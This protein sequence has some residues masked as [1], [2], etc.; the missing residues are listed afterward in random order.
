M[1]DAL[2]TVTPRVRALRADPDS[3][4]L[5]VG[6]TFALSRVRILAIGADGG[7]IGRYPVYDTH[8]ANHAVRS[9]RLGI[10]TAVRAGVDTV[11]FSAPLWAQNG[12]EG[13]A[14]ATYVR[15]IVRP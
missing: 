13:V 3:V 12:G 11:R 9:E 4:P 15:F 2:A 1:P 7:V 6:E 10:V 8:Y 14:P 5:H